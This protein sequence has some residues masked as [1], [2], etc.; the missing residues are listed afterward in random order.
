MLQSEALFWLDGHY[1]GG[2][3]AKGEKECPV[4]EELNSIFASPF[5]HFIFMD[6]ARLFVGNNDYPTIAEMK[7]FV[8]LQKTSYYFS[9]ENDCIRLLPGVS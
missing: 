6:N 3:T 9:I 2:L 8:K 1:S 7:D 4:Y 5:Q